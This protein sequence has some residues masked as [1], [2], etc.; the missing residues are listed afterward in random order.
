MRTL[1]VYRAEEFWILL[2]PSNAQRLVYSPIRATWWLIVII[3]STTTGHQLPIVPQTS[4]L[5]LVYLYEVS[6]QRCYLCCCTTS[7]NS[8]DR[9]LLYPSLSLAHHHIN[10]VSFGLTWTKLNY[11]HFTQFLM[12]LSLRLPLWLDYFFFSF[13]YLHMGI[14]ILF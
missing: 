10:Q 11:R 2:L 3:T 7:Y 14:G 12:G 6:L 8:L 5:A 1:R 13:I 9:V 4:L